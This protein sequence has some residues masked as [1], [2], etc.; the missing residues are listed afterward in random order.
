M[1]KKTAAVGGAS[2]WVWIEWPPHLNFASY[3]HVLGTPFSLDTHYHHT[4]CQIGYFMDTHIS[5]YAAVQLIRTAACDVTNI[6]VWN[7]NIEE[8][9]FII[10]G[11]SFILK[12][13]SLITH[14]YTLVYVCAHMY[15]TPTHMHA[16]TY[17]HVYMYISRCPYALADM[18]MHCIYESHL[19][20]TMVPSYS[21]I[22]S[23]HEGGHT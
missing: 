13:E 2:W 10:S 18:H 3:T 14:M 16:F 8:K 19:V 17:V 6:H 12:E 21:A 5:L 15:Y 20:T 7:S 23:L 9:D 1:H 22:A 11:S 4:A